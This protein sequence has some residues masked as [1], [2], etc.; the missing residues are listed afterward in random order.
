M[1]LSSVIAEHLF[2]LRP[3][4]YCDRCIGRAFKVSHTRVRA[5]CELFPQAP[6]RFDR[7]ESECESCGKRRIV[8]WHDAEEP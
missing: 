7:D 6:Y 8:T 2:E 5:T 4:A 3:N 1:T